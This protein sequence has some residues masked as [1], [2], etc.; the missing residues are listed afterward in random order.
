MKFIGTYKRKVTDE[1]G[2]LEITFALSG[3]DYKQQCNELEK[4]TKYKLEIGKFKEK[5][6]LNQN[7]YFWKLVDEIDIK[8]NG[9]RKDKDNLYIQLLEMADIKS[10]YLQVL[11]EALEIV[12]NNF[13]TYKII[14]HRTVNGK[15][16][17][18][19]KVW[20]GQ[21]KF[22]TAEMAAL[23]DVTLDYAE[24]VGVPTAFYREVL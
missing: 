4:D 6:S 9:H 23:I 17:V 14:E 7:A 3:Y 11:E 16:T 15:D 5:R 1:D 18:M 2:N 8:I 21:S 20:D 10:T 24:Q 12:T 22:N 19:I 13:R